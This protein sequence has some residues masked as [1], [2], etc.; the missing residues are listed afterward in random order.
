MRKYKMLKIIVV[1]VF[2]CAFFVTLW[3]VCIYDS[4]ES[5][6]PKAYTEDEVKALFSEHEDLFLKLPG[7]LE[8][9]EFWEK[10]RSSRFETSASIV[11]PFDDNRL[12]L[13]TEDDRNMIIEIFGTLKPYMIALKYQEYLEV[14][15]INE[16]RTS[17]YIIFY[18]YG[19]STSDYYPLTSPLSNIVEK[20]NS[21]GY[22]YT[23][24]NNGWGFYYFTGYETENTYSENIGSQIN[25]VE[26]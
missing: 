22:K 18:Q 3:V 23:N 21:K 9:E 13:F 26:R 8:T 10:G 12:S 19:W 11:S 20:V 15:F 6:L 4:K 16:D 14:T 1:S 24:L 7:I 17:A 25:N 5:Y 2:L